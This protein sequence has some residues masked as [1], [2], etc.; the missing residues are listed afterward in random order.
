MILAVKT[1]DILHSVQFLP[2][3]LKL[4]LLGARRTWNDGYRRLTDTG[5]RSTG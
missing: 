4:R 5:G 2:R 1:K 3:Y